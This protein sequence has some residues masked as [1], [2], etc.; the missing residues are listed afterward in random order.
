VGCRLPT[1]D[2]WLAAASAFPEDPSARNLRDQTWARHRDHTRR[3]AA[4]GRAAQAPAAGAFDNGGPDRDSAA[5]TD[6][7]QLWF[8]PVD[9]APSTRPTALIGNVAEYVVHADLPIP[10]DPRDPRLPDILAAHPHAFS[11]IGGSALSDPG[12]DPRSPRPVP[13]AEAA[14][15]FSDVGFRLAFS[16]RHIGPEAHT[17]AARLERLLTPAPYLKGK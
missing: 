1:A 2:E 5:P 15:G 13:I 10:A 14:E 4:S 9:P 3:V 7:G 16:G 17:L 12:L 6:D 8:A 11:I